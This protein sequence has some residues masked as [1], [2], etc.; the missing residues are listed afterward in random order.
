MEASHFG[1]AVTL[2]G[3][4]LGLGLGGL[5]CG[6]SCR[7]SPFSHQLVQR[8]LLRLMFL[9][10]EKPVREEN[11]LGER[12]G[13]GLLEFFP[14]VPRRGRNRG[15]EASQSLLLLAPIIPHSGQPAPV[16]SPDHFSTSTQSHLLAS[17]QS[18]RWLSTDRH[19]THLSHQKYYETLGL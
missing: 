11:C 18:A 16:Q 7:L 2:L 17:N 13:G 6:R 5:K 9:E 8:Q 1:S 4:G 10:L 14:T 3:L 19:I 15:E 12:R